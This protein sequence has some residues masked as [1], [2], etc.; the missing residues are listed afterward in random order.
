MVKASSV[1]REL[2]KASLIDRFGEFTS[3]PRPV[4]TEGSAKHYEARPVRSRMDTTLLFGRY[5]HEQQ[6]RGAKRSQAHGRRPGEKGS[7]NSQTSS[8][9]RS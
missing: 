7:I 4:N 5:K 8:V 3:Q 9:K 2:S 1:A 6:G